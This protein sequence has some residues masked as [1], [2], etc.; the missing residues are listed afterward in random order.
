MEKLAAPAF[1]SKGF[2]MSLFASGRLAAA[3]FTKATRG[4]AVCR[5]VWT[6]GLI[7]S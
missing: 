5:L 1:G 3:L 2:G 4:F 7:F 6:F